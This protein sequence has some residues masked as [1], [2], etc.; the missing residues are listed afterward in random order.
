MKMC[1]GH[2]KEKEL[3]E[4][5]EGRRNQSQR[6]IGEQLQQWEAHNHS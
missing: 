4:Y 2:D 3:Q 5:S 1:L 6:E